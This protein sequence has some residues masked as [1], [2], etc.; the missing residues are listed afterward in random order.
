MEAKEICEL[1]KTTRKSIK[2]SGGKLCKAAGISR[3]TLQKLEAGKGKVDLNN[4]S[5]CLKAMGLELYALNDASYRQV[6]QAYSD[7][8]KA[9]DKAVELQV[10]LKNKAEQKTA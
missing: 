5:A 1:V 4:V 8:V 3:P 2:W 10:V 9:L 7:V 6:E